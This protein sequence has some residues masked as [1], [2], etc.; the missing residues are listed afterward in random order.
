[1]PQQNLDE[2]IASAEGMAAKLRAVAAAARELADALRRP[3]KDL[4]TLAASLRRARALT[5]GEAARHL[6]AATESKRRFE[7]AKPNVERL[8]QALG[9]KIAGLQRPTAP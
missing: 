8:V 1:M 7:E 9:Q 6:T 3:E 4:E 5:P 2:A